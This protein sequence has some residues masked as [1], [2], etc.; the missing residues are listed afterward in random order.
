MVLRNEN[1]GEKTTGSPLQVDNTTPVGS[2]DLAQEKRWLPSFFTEA[3]FIG[4][5]PKYHV[6][7]IIPALFSNFSLKTQ[8]LDYII[9]SQQTEAG[10]LE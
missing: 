3:T 10:G 7:F 4:S 9:F 1:T 6:T 2:Q 8:T 5:F